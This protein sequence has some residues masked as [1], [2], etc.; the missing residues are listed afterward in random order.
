[1]DYAAIKKRLVMLGGLALMFLA[2]F[3]TGDYVKVKVAA[4]LPD[5]YTTKTATKPFLSLPADSKTASDKT[6][7]G[8]TQTFSSTPVVASSTPTA[9]QPIIDP[10][11]C[12][13]KGNISS[14]GRKLYHVQ[15]QQSYKRLTHMTSCFNSE[16]E[17]QAAGFTKAKR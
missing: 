5:N 9:L 4:Q 12:P 13:V 7:A 15:G 3:G 11:N 1:M 17:A 14:D 2:G 10:N 6:G 16:A 8:E